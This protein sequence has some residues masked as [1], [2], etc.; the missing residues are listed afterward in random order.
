[1][2]DD[3]P[4]PV[5]PVD[6]VPPKP[7]LPPTAGRTSAPRKDTRTTVGSRVREFVTLPIGAIAVGALVLGAI[8]GVLV[9]PPATASEEYRALV[10]T[11]SQ[12]S[13][14]LTKLNEDF[15]ELED[16]YDKAKD[17]YDAI[18]DRE[19]DI[20]TGE[21]ALD[22]REAGLDQREKDLDAREDEIDGKEAD[23]DAKSFGGG[24]QIV[25]ETVNAGTYRTT[26]ITSGLCYY[27]WLA[28]TA[29]DADI[30]D[31]NI[32]EEGTATVTL[33]NGQ[34]FESSGC[35]TWNLVG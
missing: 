12:T 21:V 23:K 5:F 9:R 22:E 33:T 4:P 6:T 16:D 13:A 20:A 24:I 35:G 31:N 30:I 34:V 7:P 3:A 17:D 1:M 32:V 15:D 10:K 11:S 2:P 8:G 14:E 28:S 26:E 18:S 19:N 29:A 27:A 25:G